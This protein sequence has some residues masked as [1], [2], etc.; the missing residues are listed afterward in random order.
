MTPL[1][2]IVA[3]ALLASL[4]VPGG[5]QDIV[6]E[7]G[8]R[9]APAPVRTDPRWAPGGPIVVRVL[10]A[11]Q[12]ASLQQAAGDVRLIGVANEAEALAAIDDATALLGFCSAELLDA[13][14]RLRWVQLYSAGV[15]KCVGLTQI[16]SGAILL[17]NGQRVSSPTIAEHTLGMMLTLTRGLAP[18]IS[19]Q[20]RAEWNP[21]LVPRQNRLE[22]NGRTML[23]VGLGGIGTEVAR[24]AHALGM[25]VI[26]IRASSRAGPDF[27]AAVGTPDDLLPFAAQAD[28]VVA[29]VPLTSATRGLFDA[30]FFRAMS[31]QAFFINVGRGQSVVTDDLVAALRSGHIAGAGL[32]VTDPEPLPPDHPLWRLPNVVITPHV[33]AQSDRIV[34]RVVAVARENL[35][36][37]VAGEPMLSVVD[38]KRGY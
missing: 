36:R 33:S 11:Q 5:A 3:A 13:A 7:L 23:V 35:R 9:A 4:G 10:A 17:T 18:H 25:R 1:R 28:V 20:S 34:E 31:P 21:E 6:T 32:D 19:A 15:E 8:L 26:A 16:R 27:V 29:S 38:P 22:I 30:E 24:R 37:Y 2:H 12:L 14:P